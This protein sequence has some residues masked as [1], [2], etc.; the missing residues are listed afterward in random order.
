MHSKNTSFPS[1]TSSEASID[2]RLRS[3][4]QCITL[5]Q[6]TVEKQSESIT[7]MKQIIETQNEYIKLM[8]GATTEDKR[9]EREAGVHHFRRSVVGCEADVNQTIADESKSRN[10]EP[11]EETAFETPVKKKAKKKKKNGKENSDQKIIEGQEMRNEGC[12]A[13]EGSG[14]TDLPAQEEAQED[15]KKEYNDKHG[16][17]QKEYDDKNG[18]GDL[19]EFDNKTWDALHFVMFDAVPVTK[20]NSQ[21][22]FRQTYCRSVRAVSGE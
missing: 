16:D 5:V 11:Q 21:C 3:I 6:V 19:K 22:F 7:E 4:I 9:G 1:A 2:E 18:D 10:E 14:R 13:E 12:E 17:T 15:T 8:A 20:S